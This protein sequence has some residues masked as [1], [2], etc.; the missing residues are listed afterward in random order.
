MGKALD[1]LQIARDCLSDPFD[2]LTRGLLTSVFAPI[3]GLERIWHL[4]EMEDLGFALLT[5]G[6]RCPQPSQRR[7][8]AAAPTLVR[9]GCFLPADQSVVSA[10]GRGRAGQL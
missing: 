10:W 5:G 7:R 2:T 3:V 4:D 9:G 6:L 8:L 1:W